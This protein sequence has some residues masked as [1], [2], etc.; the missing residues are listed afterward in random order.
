MLRLT[1]DGHEGC[2]KCLMPAHNFLQSSHVDIKYKRSLKK[3]GG[4][5]VVVRTPRFKLIKK[6]EPSL[7]ERRG[8]YEDPN[9][10]PRGDQA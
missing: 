10:P 4:R 8:E 7:A 1:I 6:P 5:N 3:I 2:P 9:Y